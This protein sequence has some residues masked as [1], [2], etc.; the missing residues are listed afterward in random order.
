M[1]PCDMT[2][3]MMS[4]KMLSC[5]NLDVHSFERPL[6]FSVKTSVK[7]NKEHHPRHVMSIKHSSLQFCFPV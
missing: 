7:D 2:H 6:L 1:D 3:F 5:H 4:S